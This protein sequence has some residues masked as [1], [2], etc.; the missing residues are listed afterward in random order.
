M[1]SS[2]FEESIIKKAQEK[3]LVKIEIIDLRKFAYDKRGSVDDRV[4]GG[5]KGMVIRVDVIYKTLEKL[6]IK[7][8]KLKIAVKNSKLKNKILLTSPKGEVFNQKKAQQLAK[9]DELVIISGHYEGIDERI[10]NFVDEEVSLGDFVMTG[11]EITVAALV[12]AVVR[13][14]PGV[15]EKQAIDEESFSEYEVNDLIKILG[16]NEILKKLKKKNI[17]KIKL[18]EYPQYTRPEEFLGLKVPKILLSGNHKEIEKWRL[19]KAWE[20]TLRLRKDLLS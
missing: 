17:K 10:K 19:K 15:L 12:D 14:I 6:K 2:F 4:Y 18:L 13:L 7:S 5:G 20:E 8:Q 16:E 3:E 11:G 9:L 1:I